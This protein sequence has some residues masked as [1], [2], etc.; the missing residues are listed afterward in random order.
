VLCEAP[1]SADRHVSVRL[2]GCGHEAHYECFLAANLVRRIMSCPR[3]VPN[4][5]IADDYGDCINMA[6][7]QL[8]DFVRRNME[9]AA[10]KRVAEYSMADAIAHAT[11]LAALDSG[12]DADRLLAVTGAVARA[13]MPA[14]RPW[15][16]DATPE[17]TAIVR[18]MVRAHTSPRQLRMTGVDALAI[19]NARLT[20][21]DLLHANY[22]LREIRD[23]GFDLPGLVTLGF[24]AEHLSNAA[25]V[26]VLDMRNIFAC[27]FEDVLQIERKYF[28]AYGAL[29][30]YLAVRIGLEG[31]RA[32]GLPNLAALRPHG[33]DRLALL[34][35]AKTVSFNDLRALGLDATMLRELDMLNTMDLH[36]LGALA[37]DAPPAAIDA[38][39]HAMHVQPAD[40]RRPVERTA[41]SL[42]PLEC[43]RVAR[44]A[45]P[46]PVQPA[47][48][49][50][51]RAPE[52]AR[53]PT[54][55]N[56]PYGH[57][58]ARVLLG[59]RGR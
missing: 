59:D 33:L 2:A 40:I 7:L 56:N 47:P 14:L 49:P 38:A 42:P 28:T 54:E 11:E 22:T 58:L 18:D 1:V 34:V 53:P 25:A 39:A 46:E 36:E 45:P 52:P 48:R 4:Q 21:D 29:I 30:A 50:P 9:V 57:I 35:F 27:T 20:L 13:P 15:L 31:H 5:T 19:L 41:P 16:P 24:R 17:Q 32:L 44:A 23:L 12:T 55:S 6:D 26:P 51:V 8:G 10:G 3:C 43:A 37:S